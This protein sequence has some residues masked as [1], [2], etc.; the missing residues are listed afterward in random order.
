[1]FLK[2]GLGHCLYLIFLYLSVYILP[3]IIWEWNILYVCL[4]F[5]LYI[6]CISLSLSTDYLLGSFMKEIYRYSFYNFPIIHIAN[7]IKAK[8]NTE[9]IY[10]RHVFAGSLIFVETVNTCNWR[11][12]CPWGALKKDKLP[13]FSSF[14]NKWFHG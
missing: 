6:I 7:I 2:S 8:K 1:M 10:M 14:Q 13:I 11:R 12:C 3:I 9:Q 5:K 4:L